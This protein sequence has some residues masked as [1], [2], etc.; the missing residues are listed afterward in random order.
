MSCTEAALPKTPRVRFD[1]ERWLRFVPIRL[2][3]TRLIQERLPPGAA[4][5][6]MSRNHPHH[7]LIIVID[8][9]DE[10]LLAGIDGRRSIADIAKHASEDRRRARALFEKLWWYDQVVFDASRADAGQGIVM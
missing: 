1:D 10:R 3:W 9:A 5:V 6:L 4:G 7:D 2:P 8:A